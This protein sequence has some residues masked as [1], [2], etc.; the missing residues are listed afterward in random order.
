M[1]S[2]ETR[3][4]RRHRARTDAKGHI[5]RPPQKNAFYRA[6]E[7]IKLRT[8]ALTAAATIGPLAAKIAIMDLAMKLGEYKSRGHG[9]NRPS[10]AHGRG[11]RGGRVVGGP[12]Q[13]AQ[14]RLRRLLGGWAAS[15]HWSDLTKRQFIA[16]LQT[17]EGRKT[18][19]GV[20]ERVRRLVA[21]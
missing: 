20:A 10:Y 16:K 21:A 17:A 15:K 13:G 14:E 9:K 12:H 8:E 3:Q 5:A 18:L 4:Q 2:A 6:L 19:R 1:T 7:V 11:S